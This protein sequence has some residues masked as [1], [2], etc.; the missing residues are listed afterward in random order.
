M[1]EPLRS[2]NDT[3]PKH[4]LRH[5]RTTT[6]LQLIFPLPLSGNSAVFPDTDIKFWIL[7]GIKVIFPDR[8]AKLGSPSVEPPTFPDTD[9][10]NRCQLL[11]ALQR[12]P[13]ARNGTPMC[14]TLC[15]AVERKNWRWCMK[16]R[17]TGDH[18]L[19]LSGNTYRQTEFSAQ[20]LVMS[21]QAGHD[22]TLV[23]HDQLFS[24]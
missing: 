10:Q 19:P 3:L 1:P 7:S 18:R 15:Q 13:K 23:W 14:R 24:V 6:Y 16:N 4:C 5:F 11:Q 2:Q 12:K 17:S 20:R 21:S 8:V 22:R 9:F